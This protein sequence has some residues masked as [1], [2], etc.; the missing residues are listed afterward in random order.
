MSH[1]INTIN[2]SKYHTNITNPCG[3]CPTR[4]K[5][6]TTSGFT[7]PLMS[8]QNYEKLIEQGWRRCGIYY[9]KPEIEK[10]CCKPYSIRLEVERFKMKNSQIKALK[11]FENFIR[12]GNDALLGFNEEKKAL[13]QQI[14]N[15]DEVEILGK[16]ENI[17]EAFHQSITEDKE[18]GFLKLGHEVNRVKIM[19]QCSLKADLQ[20]Y[21]NVFCI[22]FKQWKDLQVNIQ[23]ENASFKEF[24][25][26]FTPAIHN[27]LKEYLDINNFKIYKSGYVTFFFNHN[28][29]YFLKKASSE[30]SNKKFNL[31][32]SCKLRI[33]VI[34]AK[35]EEES[36]LIYKKYCKEVH[37]TNE[38]P[39]NYENFL[40]MQ[41]LEEAQKEED[42]PQT[43][44]SEDLIKLGC[45]HMK[46]YVDD[47]LMAVGVVDVLPKSLS[48]VYFF[49][50]PG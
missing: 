8:P 25:D 9:Y 13:V 40:C 12:K 47:R 48:S 4:S 21:S 35:F 37:N 30:I 44:E 32:N 2:I 17:M 22:Y 27:F 10:C 19:K 34:K 18:W 42:Q 46:Y 43:I 50:D 5:T 49:Y 20:F 38:T 28:T 29:S 11:K 14:K 36:F 16:L 41:A 6:W 26:R 7:C 15:D 39:S 3:Y 1:P 33:K 45:Y 31:T 23:D 24:F